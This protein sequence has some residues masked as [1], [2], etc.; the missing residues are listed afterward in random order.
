MKVVD[1]SIEME[2]R[3]DID[4]LQNMIDLYLENTKLYEEEKEAFLK[5]KNQLETMWYEW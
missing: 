3:K 1:C 4:V 5:L 2:S